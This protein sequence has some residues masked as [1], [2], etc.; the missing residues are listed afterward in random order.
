MLTYGSNVLF[1]PFDTSDMSA[2]VVGA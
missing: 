2:E 1:W